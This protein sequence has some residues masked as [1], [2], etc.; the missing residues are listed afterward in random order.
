MVSSEGTYKFYTNPFGFGTDIVLI[1][2][3]DNEKVE[4]GAQKFMDIGLLKMHI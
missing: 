1:S 3:L 4:K 2:G